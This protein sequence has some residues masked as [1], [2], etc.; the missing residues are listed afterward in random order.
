M[1]E[2]VCCRES[3]RGMACMAKQARHACIGYAS[4]LVIEC[5][6]GR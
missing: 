1:K 6:S 4:M 5:L 2:G 3:G